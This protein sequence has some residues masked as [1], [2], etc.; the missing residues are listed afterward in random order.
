M[1]SF[2][3]SISPHPRDVQIDA[4]LSRLF[5]VPTKMR[6]PCCLKWHEHTLSLSA[7]HSR[8]VSLPAHVACRCTFTPLEFQNI[9]KLIIRIGNA[10][11][12]VYRI[13]TAYTYIK[14]KSSYYSYRKFVCIILINISAVLSK[15]FSSPYWLAC[16]KC[17]L[18]NKLFIRHVR[19]R[20]KTLSR[21][22][23][24]ASRAPSYCTNDVI[25][26]RRNSFPFFQDKWARGGGSRQY[27]F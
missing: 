19:T 14:C 1:F 6:A 23:F 2:R 15:A 4:I 3:T 20:A 7:S 27:A 10:S 18:L 11:G 16:V 13:L 8:A 17:V 26:I 12:H 21:R 25:N 22:Q 9:Q 5:H 24:H